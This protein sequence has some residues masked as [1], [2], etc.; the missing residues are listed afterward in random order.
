LQGL[1]GALKRKAGKN[2]AV[3]WELP[4]ALCIRFGGVELEAFIE[5]VENV[6][7]SHLIYFTE[8]Y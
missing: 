1:V 4:L 6:P 2:D 8:T 3:Y 5:W 7:L